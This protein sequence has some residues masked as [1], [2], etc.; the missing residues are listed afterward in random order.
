LDHLQF[1]YLSSIAQFHPV[2]Y[3]HSRATYIKPTQIKTDH[4][5]AGERQAKRQREWQENEMAIKVTD[6][7]FCPSYVWR[8]H[9]L[10]A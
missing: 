8:I 5:Q 7:W 4:T 3:E 2:A 1:A 6:C 9:A 10:Y